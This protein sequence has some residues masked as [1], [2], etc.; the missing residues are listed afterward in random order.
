[1]PWSSAAVLVVPYGNVDV[2]VVWVGADHAGLFPVVLPPVRTRLDPPAVVVDRSPRAHAAVPPV[3]TRLALP[4]VVVDRSPRAYAAVP[5]VWAGLRRPRVYA[6]IAVGDGT[7]APL[8]VKAK[9]VEVISG[10]TTHLGPN[11]RVRQ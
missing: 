5:P 8:L 3:R 2:D 6:S 11:R 10:A 1:M 9:P 7:T 4:A